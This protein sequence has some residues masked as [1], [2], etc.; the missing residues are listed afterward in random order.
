MNI[1]RLLTTAAQTRPTQW[2]TVRGSQ[3]LNYLQFNGRVNR[4][5]NGLAA[6]GADPGTNISILMTNGPQ[7]LE[8][9]FAG[10]KAGCGVVPI[11]FRLHPQEYAFIIAHSESRVVVTEEAFQ[12]S[13]NQV[14]TLLDGVTHRIATG[15]AEQGFLQYEAVLAEQ[16]DRYD[17]V[18]VQPDDV[19][20]LFYTSGTTGQPKGAMLTHRN[21]WGMTQ[22]FH[23]DILTHPGD[24]EV[25][26]HAA[27]LS[28]GSGLY[29]LPNMA[30]AASHVFLETSSFAPDK[31]LQVLQD[32]AV[33]NFFAAPAMINRL[34]DCPQI[35]HTDTS[36]L[37]ALVYGGAPMMVEDLK[38]AIQKFPNMVQIYGLGETPMTITYLSQEAHRL[39][40][41]PYL[42]R[43]AS[44]GLPRTGVDVAVVDNTGQ[45]LP[46]GDMGEVVTRSEVVTKGYWNDPDAT[47]SAL[48]KGWLHTGDLGHFDDDG[49]LYLSDRSKD[50][51]IS[52]GE[53]IYPREI[54]EVLTRHTA[55]REVAVIGVPDEK[56]GEAVKAVVVLQENHAVSERELIRF[57][58]DHI[59]SYKKP[60]T[61]EFVEELPKNNYGKILKRELRAPYWQE[62][63][64][65]I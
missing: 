40:G 45:M 65:Q 6:I 46:A 22:R 38:R 2:A 57:C 39:A 12:D 26:L 16:S 20:W 10:F 1:G 25:V 59:A 48:K 18:D 37:K 28:H 43:L 34:L 30:N 31:V 29:A 15:A 21:L 58:Q 56:W 64:R 60:K 35:E 5:A 55:I 61:I 50:M 14:D 8:A 3:K 32:E 52:G 63:M 4:L 54:E 23:Q 13:L 33:T 49:Y 11:N 44:A 7:M 19:A 27:P 41:E 24:R 51:I 9:M 47:A 62:G 42:R 36:A 17:D 53:N